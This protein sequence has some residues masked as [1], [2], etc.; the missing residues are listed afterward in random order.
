MKTEASAIRRQIAQLER[1]VEQAEVDQ[2][3]PGRVEVL[4]ALL[5][6]HGRRLDE[7]EEEAP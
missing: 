4:E 1:V 3:H 5:E 2:L 7:A 6:F